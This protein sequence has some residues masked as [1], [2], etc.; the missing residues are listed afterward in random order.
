MYRL[1]ATPQQ[2]QQLFL[3]FAQRIKDLESDP[4][5]YHSFLNNCANGITR[6]TYELTP[7]PIN[8]L[9]PRIVL[10]GFSDQFAF[11]I[12]LIGDADNQSFE[13]I[14][15][16]A[17]IDVRAREVGITEDFSVQIRQ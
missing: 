14:K 10:P 16:D 13:E 1:N 15:Q 8:W 7:E 2:V 3:R 4:E 11:E 12:G 9:D 17:R 5:F 6:Q